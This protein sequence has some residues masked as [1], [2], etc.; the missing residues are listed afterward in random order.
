MRLGIRAST[1]PPPF[2]H[3]R[4]LAFPS[5]YRP[6]RRPRCGGCRASWRA[7]GAARVQRWPPPRVTWAMTLVLQATFV[8][9]ASVIPASQLD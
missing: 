8:P 7:R 1:S 2:C 5:R 4:F 6:P 9:T 3:E